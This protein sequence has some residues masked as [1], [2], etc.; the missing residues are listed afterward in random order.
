MKAIP[1]TSYPGS[2]ASPSLFPDGRMVAF[3]WDRPGARNPDIY[4]LPIGAAEPLQKTT[5]PAADLYPAWSPD[6]RFLVITGKAANGKN[7]LP[8]LS[9][10]TGEKTQLTFPPREANG[11][12]VGLIT[13][14]GD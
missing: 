3:G 7:L 12:Y 9:L 11:D 8:L 14:P 10:A 1:L 5:D 2:E 13:T 4:V 6:G